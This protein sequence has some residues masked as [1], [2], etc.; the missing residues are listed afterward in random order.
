MSTFLNRF[1]HFFSC[2][3]HKTEEQNSWRRILFFCSFFIVI[4][5]FIVIFSVF[6]D[7]DVLQNHSKIVHYKNANTAYAISDTLVSQTTLKDTNDKKEKVIQNP[8]QNA[9][10]DQEVKQDI[11]SNGAPVS[12]VIYGTVQVNDYVNIRSTPS[13]DAEILGQLYQGDEVIVIGT[14]IADQNWYQIKF[15]S[16]EGFSK[17]E[18]FKVQREAMK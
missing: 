6:K 5:C 8:D 14:S 13:T 4:V 11:L 1:Q 18:Y 17:A 2:H 15:G 3:L 12:D 7:S 10:I 9:I 16:L